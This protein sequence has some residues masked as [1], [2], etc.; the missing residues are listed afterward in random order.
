MGTHGRWG[1]AEPRTDTPMV[2][3][4]G[5]LRYR[6][7]GSRQG[8]NEIRELRG[9]EYSEWFRWALINDLLERED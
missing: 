7:K 5:K 8:F 9:K 4:W 2:L 3:L 1:H 6:W